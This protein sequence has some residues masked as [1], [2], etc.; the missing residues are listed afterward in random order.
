MAE[1][2]RISPKKYG[3]AL[4]TPNKLQRTL[5]KYVLQIP[6]APGGSVISGLNENSQK[7]KHIGY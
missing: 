3:Y 7:S 5:A 4:N 6:I 2:W 1:D